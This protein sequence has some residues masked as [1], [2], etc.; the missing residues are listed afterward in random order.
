MGYPM[1]VAVAA[2][3]SSSLLLAA[4]L[5]AACSGPATTGGSGGSAGAD[6]GGTTTSTPPESGGAAGNA[7]S[8]G[9]GTGGS[10][11][12]EAA[13]WQS[14]L[15]KG[16]LDGAVLSVWGSAP[17][18]VYAVG[19]PLGNSGF[20][21]LVVRFDGAAWH[22]LKVGGAGTYWWVSGSGP[23]DVWIVGEEGRI[24]HWDGVKPEEHSSGV[25]ATLWGIW[26]A[27]ADDVWAVGGTP[28]GMPGPDTDIVLHWD[29]AVWSRE[30]LPGAPLGRALFKVWGSASDDLYV[31]GEK[32]TIWRRKGVDWALES[33]GSFTMGRLFTVAGCSAT[34]VYAVGSSVVLRSDG[35]AFKKVDVTLSNLVNGVT[36][37]PSGSA[38]I[39]GFGGLKQRLVAGVWLDDLAS[40]PFDDLH[41]VWSDGGGNY[42]AVGGDFSSGPMAGKKRAGVVARFGKGTV[43]S[44]ISP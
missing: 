34:E 15:D 5:A 35:K 28:G 20:E 11:A 21:S 38:A 31:V 30:A 27:S 4:V 19:G 23:N 39:V 3:R 33:D 41:A 24:T 6:A 25:S 12:A 44:S 42:W 36:C 16:D 8:S 32:G 9:S 29:G 37:G 2:R 10:G 7:G 40:M 18:D 26:A 17:D 1:L 43:A 14:V 22:R 13:A